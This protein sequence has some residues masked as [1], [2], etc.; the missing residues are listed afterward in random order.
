LLGEDVSNQA[1]VEDKLK[2]STFIEYLGD[3]PLNNDG[4]KAKFA[5]G[6]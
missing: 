6:E 5:V 3:L 4:L 1:P 2:Q